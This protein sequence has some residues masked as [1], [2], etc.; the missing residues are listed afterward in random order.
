MHAHMGNNMTVGR[1]PVGK[2]GAVRRAYGEEKEEG[3]GKS[4]GKGAEKWPKHQKKKKTW[5]KGEMVL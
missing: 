5:G 1:D 2:T 3:Y 4:S